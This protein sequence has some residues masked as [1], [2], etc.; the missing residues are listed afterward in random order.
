MLSKCFWVGLRTAEGATHVGNYNEY[1]QDEKEEEDG[2][3]PLTLRDPSH[4]GI[5]SRH[6]M[7]I[8][9]A[10]PIRLEPS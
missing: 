7:G 10:V 4:G 8:T 2:Y 5:C 9:H 3:Q 6:P 1:R